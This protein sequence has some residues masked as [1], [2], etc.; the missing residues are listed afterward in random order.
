MDQIGSFTPEQARLLWQD[1]QQRRFLKPEVARNLPERRLPDIPSPHRVFVLNT[2]A[3]TI[4]PYACMQIIGTSEKGDRTV[5]EVKKPTEIDGQYLFNSEYPI[6]EA[7]QDNSGIGWAYRF[8]VVR[9]TGAAPSEANVQYRPIV[10]SWD[11]EECDGPFIVYGEDS[12]IVGALVGRIDSSARIAYEIQ[13]ELQDPLLA[14]DSTGTADYLSVRSPHP[15]IAKPPEVAD[16]EIE[17]DNPWQLDA[18]CGSKVVLQRIV[19]DCETTPRWQVRQVEKFK[20]RWIKF[21]FSADDPT[22]VTVDA[23]WEGEDPESCGA[24]VT[25]EYPLGQPC[26]DSDVIAF[27]D[28]FTDTY[29]AITSPSAMLG[30]AEEMEIV[31]ALSF[32]GCSINY[33]KQQA[34]VFPCGSEPSL[35]TISPEFT[36]VDV[37]TGVSFETSQ[38]SCDANC[39][40]SWNGTTE[41]WELV[42]PCPEGCSC[43][44]APELP[45]GEWNDFATSYEAPC[46]RSVITG[47][48]FAKAVVDVCA[49]MTTSPT[50]IPITDCPP[51]EES[52]P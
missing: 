24:T 11:I 23:F 19:E 45:P 44:G 10:D 34:K 40:Y 35:I 3:E 9:M 5:I 4:P 48:S 29:Q 38:V 27:Y 28:P 39:S 25:V 6:P 51:E 7:D 33:T 17:F 37:L 26:V 16:D 15:F 42:T 52:E 30:D 31:Q 18:I 46:T 22:D 8:G 32:D 12:S 50:I 20:A 36:T 14:T 43:G 41:E 2:E 21:Q 49:F 47:L 1:Y 13:A